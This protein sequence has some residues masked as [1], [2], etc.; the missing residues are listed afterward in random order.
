M[1]TTD[2]DSA[3][4]PPLRRART[5]DQLLEGVTNR[6]PMV[7]LGK[8]GALIERVKVGDDVRILKHLD[9][10]GDW[11]CRAT[12]DLECRAV[13]IW[14]SG[15]LDKLPSCLDHAT[16]ECAYDP[17]RRSGAILMHD[18]SP[19]M[20]DTVDAPLPLEQHRGLLEHMAALHAAFW[21]FR[22]DVGLLPLGTRYVFLSPWV[23]EVERARG[24]G[25]EVPERLIPSGW[26]R[27]QEV[28]PRSGALA[29]ELIEDPTPL[30]A[31][32]LRTPQTL[33]HGDWK[34]GNLGTHPDGRT[35]LLDWGVPGAAPACAELL[36][37]LSTT[38]T[39]VPESIESA[40]VAYRRAL[41]G[42]G[43]DTGDW[44]EAQWGLSLVGT[45]LLLGWQMALGDPEL[46][47]WWDQAVA[48]SAKWLG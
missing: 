14:R 43:I 40:S 1:T 9:F 5:V 29:R 47:A 45:F 3:I 12:G 35:I 19:W 17:D 34:L 20:I 42:Q 7:T 6:T 46:L 13:L 37:Y 41:E 25:H 15:L 24:E 39:R 27:L 26:E 28:A 38:A 31:A 32:L 21:D 8:S 44:W 30:A 10:D 2:A 11:V 23:A 16:V 33:I 4:V 36:W 18:V 22:D 48:E